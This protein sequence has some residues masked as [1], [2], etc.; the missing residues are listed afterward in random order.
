M[1]YPRINGSISP[2]FMGSSTSYDPQKGIVISEEWRCAG[3]GL[4]GKANE[5]RVNNIPFE[6]SR[7]GRISVLKLEHSGKNFINADSWQLLCNENQNDLSRHKN[8]IALAQG[9]TSADYTDVNSRV[10]IRQLAKDY[11]AGEDEGA[12]I[13]AEDLPTAPNALLLYNMLKNKVSTYSV[14]GYVLRHTTNV[15][16]DYAANVADSYV[17]YVYST[18]KLVAEITNEDSWDRPCPDRLVYKINNIERQ[19][20]SSVDLLWGWRKLPSQEVSTANN[21]IDITTEYWLAGWNRLVYEK[22]G[23]DEEFN[24]A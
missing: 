15:G 9:A 12:V 22:Y 3:D 13:P 14:G 4:D 18:A 10:Y 2:V 8:V 5:C 1:P 24:L 11:L 20:E 23:S 19:I 7:N 6:L 17:E 21:R 16:S